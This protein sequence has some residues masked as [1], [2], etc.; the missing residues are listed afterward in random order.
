MYRAIAALKVFCGIS[1]TAAHREALDRAR[2]LLTP[3]GA[4]VI[5][6][7]IG[8]KRLEVDLKSDLDPRIV[9]EA[10]RS[11]AELEYLSVLG[12]TIEL[13]EAEA[14]SRAIR[15][16]NDER[17]WEAH[18]VLEGLWRA[19]VGPE[20]EVLSGLIKLSAAYVHLQKG[21]PDRYMGL[22]RASLKHLTASGLEEYRS[23]HVSQLRNVVSEILG[24]GEP[25]YITLPETSFY[26]GRPQS[27]ENDDLP[28][29]QG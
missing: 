27:G 7:R 16:F 19:Q 28:G 18:E 23:I 24:L 21:R 1:S 12:P 10:L 14:L 6:V 20:K 8:R 3:L 22:L 15:L 29:R 11:W 5:D 4:Q 13:D 2:A 9:S 25:R 17:F 26:R